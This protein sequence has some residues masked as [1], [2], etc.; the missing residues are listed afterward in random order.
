MVGV[1]LVRILTEEYVNAPEF[2]FLGAWVRQEAAAVFGPVEEVPA[3]ELGDGPPGTP[4]LVVDG[5]TLI[6]RRSLR[7]MGEVLAATGR[8]VAP[9][10][11]D[12]TSL[13]AERPLYTLR[14]YEAL[15]EAFLTGGAGRSEEAMR[16]RWGLLVPGDGGAAQLAG[17]PIH[18]W[19]EGREGVV[20]GEPVAAAG[21]CHRFADYYGQARGDVADLLAAEGV[22]EPRDGG[23]A[24]VLEVGC[25]RGA[26]GGLL[27]E[28]FGC[29]VTGVELNP[30]VA[31]AAREHLHRV[32]AGDFQRVSEDLVAAGPFD[33][34]VAL[35]LF[36]HLTE[37]ERFLEVARRLVRPGGRIV[38]SVPN[39]GH[40][41][42]VTDLLAGRWDYVPIGLLCYTHFRFFTRHTLED[43]LTRCGFRKFTIL[44][45]E[46]ALPEGW[47]RL[48]AVPGG[49]EPDLENLAAK[50][51]YVVASVE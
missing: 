19:L 40:H 16:G 6:T 42:I 37:Q 22:L 30:V 48:G 26:T 38:L 41:S 10:P 31:R 50:G 8:P 3:R 24:G 32:V 5:R 9:V 43:W 39:V 7:R 44:A 28:R 2:E 25:G 36:E 20:E 49:V 21:L 12:E 11:L 46:T 27:Q 34:L 33:A 29:R 1:R 45:Q 47:R 35:E 4:V 18:R 17:A 15:E 51:F 14:E 13:V 23:P